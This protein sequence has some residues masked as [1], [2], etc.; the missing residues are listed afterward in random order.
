MHD[1]DCIDDF[2]IS[3]CALLRYFWYLLWRF[4]RFNDRIDAR[5]FHSNL[6]QLILFQVQIPQEKLIDDVTKSL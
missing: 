1:E 4:C 3:S 2:V 6:L 5:W